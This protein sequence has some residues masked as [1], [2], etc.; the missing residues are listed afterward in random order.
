MISANNMAERRIIRQNRDLSELKRMLLRKEQD[1]KAAHQK[2]KNAEQSLEE[3]LD[4]IR[5]LRKELRS[6]QA[7]IKTLEGAIPHE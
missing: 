4:D 2:Q 6:A 1:R 5:K 7:Q 3:S